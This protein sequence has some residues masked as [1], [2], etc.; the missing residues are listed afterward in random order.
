[1]GGDPKTDGLECKSLLKW[2]IWR[3]PNFRKPLQAYNFNMSVGRNT[4]ENHGSSTLSWLDTRHFGDMWIQY[5][6]ICMYVCTVWSM[7]I[8]IHMCVYLYIYI[9]TYSIY[10][11]ILRMYIIY[12]LYYIYTKKETYC[13][14][15]CTN[16]INCVHIKSHAQTIY[17]CQ[18]RHLW[19]VSGKPVYK[20]SHE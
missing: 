13:M 2:M 7:Y 9:Y 4:W 15:K 18:S 11:F 3:Y 17:V 16:V 8:Y 14:Y 5:Q 1:M 20:P 12:I 10:I 6:K 19:M